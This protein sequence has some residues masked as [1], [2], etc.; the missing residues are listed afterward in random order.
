MNQ[1]AIH[2]CPV[3]RRNVCGHLLPS[4]EST[5]N[6]LRPFAKTPLD[7]GAARFAADVF[8]LLKGAT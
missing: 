4:R 5:L 1:T 6:Q 8:V 2:F 7:M 3:C